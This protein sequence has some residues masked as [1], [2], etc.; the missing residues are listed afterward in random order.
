MNIISNPRFQRIDR[1]TWFVVYHPITFRGQ[2]ETQLFCF[3]DKTS[4]GEQ[5]YKTKSAILCQSKP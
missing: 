2:E 1:G 4:S 5:D 3:I